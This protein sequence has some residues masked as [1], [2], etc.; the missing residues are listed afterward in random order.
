M[1]NELLKKI[2]FSDKSAQVY[3]GLLQLGPSSVRN[4][5]EFCNLNRGSTYD[6]LKWL[7]ERGL[8]SFYEKEA[9]QHFVVESPQ[10]LLAMVN[11]ETQN[12]TR[13]SSELEHSL[14]ELTALYN[15]GG[16]RPIARYFSQAEL[17]AILSD[18]L[19][20]CEESG[21]LMYRVYSTEG[22]RDHLYADFSTFSDVR[23]AKNI[24]VRAIALGAGGELR[25]LDERKWLSAPETKPTYII[26]Y[27]G[28]AVYISLN[29]QG[30][31]VGVVIV[32]E[33]VSQ[34]QVQIFDALWEKI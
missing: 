19:A 34:T 4:L 13:A 22:I 10:K 20:T 9:K 8:V 21:E 2:G 30:E 32:N 23:V 31:P 24:A 28:K 17:P 15:R 26:L 14:P 33:G 5:A 16:E 3:L 1:N 25:G 11:E 6:A 12:L 29:T 18:V 7:E 27:P